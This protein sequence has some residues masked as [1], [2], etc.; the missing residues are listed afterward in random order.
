LDS[1][2]LQILSAPPIDP[3][4]ADAIAAAL[5]PDAARLIERLEVFSEIDSTNRYLL[6]HPPS[7]GRLAVCLAEYQHAGRGRRGRAWVA[8]AGAA[9]CLSVGWRFAE[10]PP[11]LSALTLACG[12]AARRALETQAGI[13]VGLKWPND[14]VWDDRKLGGILVE[15]SA[16]H[17]GACHAVVGIG[18]NVAMPRDLLRRVSDWPRGAVDL[19]E[20]ACGEPA[21]DVAPAEPPRDATRGE[22]LFEAVQGALS[23][24]AGRGSLLVEAPND[25]LL[26]EEARKELPGRSALA[27][28]LVGAFADV[29]SSYA[30]V[31]FR[32]YLAEFAA[33]DW[34]AGREIRIDDPAGALDGVARGIDADGALR[35]NVG[36]G[37]VRRVMSGDVSVRWPVRWARTDA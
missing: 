32:P 29:L 26:R 35:V 17:R 36:G 37:R 5:A 31:G 4:D 3:L 9:L 16:G 2:A 7:S 1:E 25:S 23:G 24:E 28:A 8:P 14:L 20:A 33:A 10:R 34:L 18:I 27:A 12:V 11:D 21:H 22:P 13:S 19:R 15:L 6:E 30:A